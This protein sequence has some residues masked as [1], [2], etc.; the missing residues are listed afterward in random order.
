SIKFA[1]LLC[2]TFKIL[3]LSFSRFLTFVPDAWSLLTSL[4]LF[5]P[6]KNLPRQPNWPHS[7]GQHQYQ[8]Q[9]IYSHSLP[10]LRSLRVSPD[11]YQ[12]NQTQ[13]QSQC[14]CHILP[15]HPSHG[16]GHAHGLWETAQIV[17][18]KD[19]I[20]RLRGQ[21]GAL[22]AHGD[23]H[24]GRPQAWSIIDPI[25]EHPHQAPGPGGRVQ[26]TGEKAAMVVARKRRRRGLSWWPLTVGM[27]GVGT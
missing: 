27:V 7:I 11:E 10:D 23:A 2:A 19:H 8:T 6:R 4:F 21:D 16:L 9:G 13:F 12:G 25:A 26:P 3:H 24:V 18:K 5:I 14:Q 15:H 1:S 22:L 17:G 20:G